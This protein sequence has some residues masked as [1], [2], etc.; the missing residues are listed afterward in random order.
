MALKRRRINLGFDRFSG[1][2][3]WAL[4]I[5]IFGIWEPHLFLTLDTFH[6]VAS[7]YAVG[8]IV[9]LAVLVPLITGA[10]DLSV[11][12]TVN[13]SAIIAIQLQVSNGWNMWVAIAVAIGAAVMI[14][15]VNGFVVVKLQVSSFIATLGMATIIAAV[16][17]IVTG[18]GQPDAPTSTAWADLTQHTILGFQAIVFYLLVI[19]LIFWW[20]LEFTPA[21]RYLYAVGGNIEAARLSGVKVGKWTW[22][23]LITSA[24]LSG[25]AGVLYGSLSGPSLTFGASLLLPAFAAVF[26][27]S[28]Q[29]KPGRPNVWGTLLAIYVLA[30]GVT[31]LQ[32]ATGAQWLDDMFNGVALIIAVSFAGWRQR[33]AAA[34]R[35]RPG[36]PEPEEPAPPPEPVDVG[37]PP[38]AGVAAATPPE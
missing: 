13:L 9:S 37:G 35:L 28:T 34:N 32:L 7:E 16:Q 30:I 5:L 22:L 31:G 11:G 15:V 19:A 10:F 36:S 4:F 6:S 20:A 8:G 17:Y 33:A 21:G 38:A 3:L 18:G 23:S 24:T 14:G 26:L 29:L 1:F 2:Y 27:G 25:V 12:A